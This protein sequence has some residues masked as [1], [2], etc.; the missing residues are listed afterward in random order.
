[1]VMSLLP[2]WNSG[3]YF[4]TGSSIRILPC[5]KSFITE[6]V[7]ATTLVSEAASKMV[8]SVI[9]SRSGSSARDPYAF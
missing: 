6:G 9:G 4:V 8:S 2:P 5:S 7:V 3:R 1:M